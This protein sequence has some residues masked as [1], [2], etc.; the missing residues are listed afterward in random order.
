MTSVNSVNSI[1]TRKSGLSE[2]Y[3]D[4]AISYVMTGKGFGNCVPSVVA[5][6]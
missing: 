6:I 1:F 2:P 3:F 4:I 5:K